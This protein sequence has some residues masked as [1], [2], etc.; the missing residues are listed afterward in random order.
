MKKMSAGRDWKGIVLAGGAGTRLYPVTQVAS[1][2]LLPVYDKP[3]VYYPISSLMLAGIRQILIISTPVDLPRFKDILGDGSR[4]G[5]QFHYEEQPEPKGIAQ[6]F[7]I[8][9]KF[10]GKSS[11]CLILGDNIFYG[12]HEFLRKALKKKNGASVFGYR[13]ADPERY[14]VVDFD[15]EGNVLSIVEKPKQP[16]SDYAVVGLYC[17]DNTVIE[18][19]ENLKP[20]ARGELEITDVNNAYL[21]KGQ[22]RVELLKRGMAWLDTGTPQSLLD[23]SSFIAAIE[24][25]QGLKV[26]CLEEIALRAGYLSLDEFKKLTSRKNKGA[27]YD[28]LRMIVKEF[29]R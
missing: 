25:R 23:A 16:K 1:K 6:A 7:V 2:Q 18:I 24:T 28:Y 10:I 9:K 19:S 21:H 4:F 5:V 11:V 14:G 8:G 20:S 29:E 3:M 26:G 15:K 12:D 22:L 27:Y 13:V 17:Y